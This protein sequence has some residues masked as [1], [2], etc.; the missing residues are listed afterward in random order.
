MTSGGAGS[1]GSMLRRTGTPL[2]RAV[3][4]SISR[5]A[6]SVE[7]TVVMPGANSSVSGGKSQL[8]Q[9]SGNGGG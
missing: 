3:G 8:N 5:A 7:T 1:R 9:H 2:S 6:S 4:S